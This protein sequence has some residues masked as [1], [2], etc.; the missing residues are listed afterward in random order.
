VLREVKRQGIFFVDSVTS[1]QSVA[2]SVAQAAGVPSAR[3]AMFL[4]RNEATEAVERK[5]Y[6]LSERARIEGTVIGI[7][8]AK[9]GTLKALQRVL[10]ELAAQ[11]FEFVQA[12]EAVR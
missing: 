6:V 5:L 2:Y 11:G 7:G 10:P 4:D 1:R 8:H 9:L 3:N 12:K